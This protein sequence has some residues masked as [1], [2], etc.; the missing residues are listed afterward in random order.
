MR[1]IVGILASHNE[2]YD[3]F[4]KIWIENIKTITKNDNFSFYFIYGGENEYINDNGKWI[5]LYYNIQE[6]IPNMLRKS[7]RFF[8][9]VN[10]KYDGDFYILRTNLSTLFDFEKLYKWITKLP[11]NY[12]FGGSLIDGYSG[13]LTKISGTNMIFSTEILK[14]LIKNQDR[15][16]Y[17]QNEDVVLSH[18]II[19]N[20]YPFLRFKTIKRLDFLKDSTIMY[21]RC[22][23][24]TQLYDFFCYRFKSDDRKS[25][26]ENMRYILYNNNLDKFKEYKKTSEGD[27]FEVFS[28]CIWKI[29]ENNKP[30]TVNP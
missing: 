23:L 10:N 22:S 13:S 15:F 6:T 19:L 1:V 11:T 26:I 8:E 3:E 27:V 9:Y 24:N 7:C 21:H 5:D 29:A 20:L 25:D 2:I 18:M 16:I 4:K 30:I 17:N 14:F 28:N 12:F